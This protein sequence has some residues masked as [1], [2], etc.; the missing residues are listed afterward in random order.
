MTDGIGEIKDAV[1]G[2]PRSVL[3]EARRTLCSPPQLTTKERRELLRQGRGDAKRRLTYVSEEGELVSPFNEMMIQEANSQI[4]AV[5]LK[6]DGIMFDL[7]VFLEHE[8]TRRETL[9]GR[10]TELYG[11]R[12]AVLSAIRNAT[13]DGDA[14]ASDYLV[15]KRKAKRERDARARFD[16]EEATLR[17]SIRGIAVS[18]A[19]AAEDYRDAED[20]GTTHE[21]IVRQEY[22]RKLSIYLY[23]ASRYVRV[24]PEMVNDG[25][26]SNGPRRRHDERFA[27][28]DPDLS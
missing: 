8:R 19:A 10:L 16:E 14:G 23:G 6:C 26:L 21:G 13:F 18:M 22:L 9:Y 1:S 28:Y 17:K 27:G 3:V 7:R 11:E 12:D 24:A 25:S 4:A 2:P 5:W 20:I 15:S